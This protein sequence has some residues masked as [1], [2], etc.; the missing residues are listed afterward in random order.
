MNR[1]LLKVNGAVHCPGEISR[2]KSASDWEG[3]EIMTPISGPVLLNAGSAESAPPISTGDELWIW[4]HEDENHGSGWGL[5][6]KAIAQTSRETG[7][8]TAITLKNVELMPRPFGFRTP[9]IDFN[10]SHT[11]S[12]LKKLR[13]FKA[14]QMPRDDFDD[15]F[16]LVRRHTAPLDDA[17]KYRDETEWGRHIR[18][19]QAS[20][21]A[22]LSERH[23]KAQKSR[24]GQGTFRADLFK[25]YEG[26]CVV[27]GCAVPEAL[28]AAHIM[29][30]TGEDVW[31]QRANGLLLRRDLHALFDNMLWSIEPKSNVF[32][33]AKK[34]RTS[35]Y[36]A[37]DRK[38]IAHSA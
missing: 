36:S 17:I 12:Y 11:L 35:P 10:T 31:D 6:A 29:P 28:E 8:F 34:L 20:I 13:H 18:D 5:T 27:T 1:Y 19:H 15:F 14:V 33:L 32:R 7:E 16:T 9:G 21:M 30:H 23:L 3:F 22:G 38:S 4:T 37:F 2:P 25:L 26:R 24:Q